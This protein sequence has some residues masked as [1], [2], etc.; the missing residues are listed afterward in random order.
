MD[1]FKVSSSYHTSKWVGKIDQSPRDRQEADMQAVAGKHSLTMPSALKVI[2]NRA[3][4][5]QANV[6][7]R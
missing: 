2:I 4:C 7:E 6:S 5:S 3:E 1:I